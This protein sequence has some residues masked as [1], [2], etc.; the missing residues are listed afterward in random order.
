[1]FLKDKKTFKTFGITMALTT[2]LTQTTKH[3]NH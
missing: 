1:M 2:K 3:L